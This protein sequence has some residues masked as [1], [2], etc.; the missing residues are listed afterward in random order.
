MRAPAR[1]IATARK[2]RK[3]LSLPEAL[4][5]A[6]LKRREAGAPIFR[7][8]H[9]VGP[10]ILDFYCAK[11]TLA[12]EID[13]LA[14]DGAGAP[15]RDA[16]RDAWLTGQGV[17]VVRIPAA[18]VLRSADDAADAIARLAISRRV[19]SAAPPPPR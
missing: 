3:N 17:T 8:Q 7:R 4:L 13:G 12:V 10:Y 6:R 16:R 1:T 9:P 11:A 18:D 15:E 5:W 14:H 2:L 19:E